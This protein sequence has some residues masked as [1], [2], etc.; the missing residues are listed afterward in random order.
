MSATGDISGIDQD[1]QDVVSA[2]NHFVDVGSDVHIIVG[3]EKREFMINEQLICDACPYFWNAFKGAFLEAET[4]TIS[5]P[6]EASERFEDLI[7]W[8]YNDGF[9]SPN[10]TWKK[11]S[12]IW[13]FAD[14]Y[15]IDKLQNDVVDSLYRKFAS[16]DQGINISYETL[17]YIVENTSHMR[18]LRRL[19]AD[20]LANG[21]SLQQ[22]PSR[23]SQ[24][25]ADFLEDMVLAMKRAVSANGPTNIALLTNPISSY[26]SSAP[27][28]CRS[29]AMPARAPP[30]DQTSSEIYCD[31]IHCRNKN[32]LEPIKGHM[33]ICTNHNLKLCEQCRHSHHGHRKKLFTFTTAPYKDIITGESLIVDGHI[34]DSGFYCDGPKCDPENKRETHESW[35]LMSGDRYHCLDCDNLD[36][37]SVCIRGQLSC[38]DAG[39]SLLRIRPTFA[40]RVPLTQEISIK[41]RQER[42]AKKACWRCASTEHA[43]TACEEKAVLAA[44]VPVEN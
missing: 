26:Y 14:Q 12:T 38:K 7:R 39:H 35:A 25:P 43:T 10:E 32:P 21:I 31:G 29:N 24:I 37:C 3:P 36:Y 4:K 27:E 40:K 15:Q 17:D 11:L 41:Q 22:L 1:M 33:H 30:L 42:V 23:L 19:F 20:M 2:E 5:L 16:R 18:P 28:S 13:I 44:D 6:D 34:N 9:P 8:L